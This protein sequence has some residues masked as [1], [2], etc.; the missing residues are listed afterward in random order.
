MGRL[1]PS[2]FEDSS[3]LDLSPL[4]VEDLSPLAGLLAQFSAVLAFSKGGLF[5]LNHYSIRLLL[6]RLGF[7]PLR[8]VSFLNEATERL[9]LI[10]RGGSYEFFHL[11]FRD[12]MADAYGHNAN[13]QPPDNAKREIEAHSEMQSR[14]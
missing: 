8:Y 1:F 7:V 14:S 5:A 4:A 3:P 2:L 6:W 12:Y 13:G 10:R 9:F 11:T